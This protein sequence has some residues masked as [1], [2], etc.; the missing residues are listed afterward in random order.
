MCILTS[1]FLKLAESKIQMSQQAHN[2]VR[3]LIF[4]NATQLSLV[5]VNVLYSRMYT[6]NFRYNYVYMH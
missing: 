4:L 2:L 1:T 6:E 5:L 3:P